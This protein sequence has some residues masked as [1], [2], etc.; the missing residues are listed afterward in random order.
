MKIMLVK[1]GRIQRRKQL[2]RFR[3]IIAEQ[4]YCYTPSEKQPLLISLIPFVVR[5]LDGVVGDEMDNERKSLSSNYGESD[6]WR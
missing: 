3:R 4:K 6:P 5:K 2:D 1:L